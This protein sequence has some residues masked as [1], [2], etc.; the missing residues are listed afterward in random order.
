[1]PKDENARQL[2]YLNRIA[3]ER[4]AALLGIKQPTV[5]ENQQPRSP[6][7][8]RVPSST[9]GLTVVVTA[10]EVTGDHGTGILIYRLLQDVRPV[11]VVR[12]AQHYDGSCLFGGPD[13]VLPPGNLSREEAFRTALEWFA[14][15]QIKR[16]LCVP[17]FDHELHISIALKQTYGVPLIL[18]LMDDNCLL[19]GCISRQLMS[20]AI[21]VADLRLAIS[22]EMQNAYQDAFRRKFWILPPLI[23]PTLICTRAELSNNVARQDRG[24]VI[25]NIWNQDYLERFSAL[26]RGSGLEVDWYQNT[27]SPGWLDID[28]KNLLSAGI[29]VHDPLPVSQLVSILRRRTFALIPVGTLNREDPRP[30][31]GL[32]SLPSKIPF[33]AGAAATPLIVLGSEASAAATFVGH[34]RLGVTT[35]Y[36]HSGLI[37]A[38]EQVSAPDF[39]NEARQGTEQIIESFSAAGMSEWVFRAAETGSPP[40]QRF[41]ELMNYRRNEFGYYVSPPAPKHIFFDF[42]MA[43]E[44]LCRLKS[45]GLRPDFIIDVGS[46]TGVW[47][48]TIS[49]LFPNARF[50]L[51]D[52]LLGQ[53]EKEAVQAQVS[54][55]RQCE[56]LEVA[57]GDCQGQVE[58]EVSSNLYGSSYISLGTNA[59]SGR[60]MR[61]PVVTL[62]QIAEERKVTGRGIIK[63]DVQYAEHLV[64]QGATN[65]LATAIDCVVVELSIIRPHP[66]I[67]SLMEMAI[68]MEQLGFCWV[69]NAGEWRSM[70]DG[71]LEQMD[72]VFLKEGFGGRT[73]TSSKHG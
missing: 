4:L 16:V 49:E 34:F 52:P 55:I 42:R 1:V 57:V 72:L 43:Y 39:R 66:D 10:N 40:D 48:S 44:S 23:D 50:L 11:A 25:G 71:R 61:V 46:S 17:F 33:I 20:E 21:D 14:P 30:S 31:M 41:E 73:A 70:A 28:V 51:I 45:W 54:R 9:E 7:K 63:I 64:I 27:L 5:V 19:S 3:S 8:A 67:R 26:I 59:D 6:V 32:Y 12:T 65:L 13:L 47:S 18:Y 37:T 58:M 29:F 24:I 36:S 22:P 69:D 38:V 53:Y 56:L 68:R 62:D 60:R 15:G 2:L 35:D